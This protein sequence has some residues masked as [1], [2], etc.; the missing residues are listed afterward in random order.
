MD[1]DSVEMWYQDLHELKA[2]IAVLKSELF[3]LQATGLSAMTLDKIGM[4]YNISK[5]TEQDAINLIERRNDIQQRIVV[6]EQRVEI[7]ENALKALTPYEY[8][9]IKRKVIDNE[10]FYRICGDLK[11]SDRNARRAKIRALIKLERTI[12][13]TKNYRW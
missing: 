9:I 1:S 7:L 2:Q 6:M 5:P 4:T 3:S 11:V 12:F 13:S 10:P 8:E